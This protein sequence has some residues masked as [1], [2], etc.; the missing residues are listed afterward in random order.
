M[1]FQNYMNLDITEIKVV[2]AGSEQRE[3]MHSLMTAMQGRLLYRNTRN[4]WVLFIPNP[5]FNKNQNIA[6]AFCHC[7]SR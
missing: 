7:H 2:I 3:K 4:L 6:Y 5:I 1:H